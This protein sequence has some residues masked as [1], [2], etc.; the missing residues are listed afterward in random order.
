MSTYNINT[1]VRFMAREEIALSIKIKKI[2][3]ALQFKLCYNWLNI[4]WKYF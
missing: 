2:V 4:L 3:C 1:N